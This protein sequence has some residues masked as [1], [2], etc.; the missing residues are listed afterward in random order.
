MSKIAEW[1][2]KRLRHI[3]TKGHVMR[4]FWAAIKTFAAVS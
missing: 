3:V 1:G 2:V 4:P